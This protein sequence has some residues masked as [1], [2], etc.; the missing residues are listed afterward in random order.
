MTRKEERLY[1]ETLLLESA[2]WRMT[3][4][5]P[6]SPI[7]R[8]IMSRLEQ[9]NSA[10]EEPVGEESNQEPARPKDNH[11]TIRVSFPDG[12]Y[13]RVSVNDVHKE[14]F[15]KSP[16]GYRWVINEDKL[17]AYLDKYGIKPEYDTKQEEIEAM[18]QEHES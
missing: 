10:E 8:E 1:L 15:T 6:Y 13:H 18:W 11:T 9:L 17:P 14:S 12:S 16:V 7:E 3:E 2:R 4:D 5:D